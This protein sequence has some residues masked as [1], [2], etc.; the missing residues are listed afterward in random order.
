MSLITPHQPLY[1]QSVSL[2]NCEAFLSVV[3][4]LQMAAL[5]QERRQAVMPHMCHCNKKQEDNT[6][7]ER[8]DLHMQS[9]LQLDGHYT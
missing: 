8:H 1:F 4:V 2:V 7:I 5:L 9:I 6:K 3:M